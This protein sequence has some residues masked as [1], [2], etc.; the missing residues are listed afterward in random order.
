[1]GAWCE[2]AV[3][4]Q[5]GDFRLEVELALEREIGVLFG[6]SGAGKTLTLRILAGLLSPRRGEFRLGG[7]RLFQFPG[8]P[9]VP[10]H[11]RRIGLVHQHLALFPHL[12]VLENVAYGLR[13]VQRDRRARVWLQRM[14]L[15]G[16]ESRYPG[17]LSGGQQQRVALARAL[18]PEPE[19]LL[20]DEP[21]SALDGPLR[22]GLRRE[23]KALQRETG[24]PLLYVTHHLEDLCA[25]GR[26]VFFLR[27]GRLVGSFPVGRLWEAGAQ[28]GVWSA[29]GWGTVIQGIVECRAGESVSRLCWPGGAL[30]LAAAGVPEG[31]ATALVAPQVVKILYPGL[32]V[33]PQLAANVMEGTVLERYQVG[34]TCTLHVEAAGLHWHVEFPSDSYRD[35][36]LREGASLRISVRARFVELGAATELRENAR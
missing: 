11:A 25:L 1:V 6:P 28:A 21:F 10:A 22:R 36:D 17:E 15:G 35:L 2:A 34:S 12:S 18:A 9:S 24:I 13:G 8:G 20:L 23:L 27:A 19:L 26:R 30:E 32:P 16:L 29:L 33:D 5:L 14:R 4:H 3:E 7:R 31:P